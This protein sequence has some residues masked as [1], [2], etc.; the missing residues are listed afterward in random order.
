MKIL[1]IANSEGH[2][3]FINYLKQGKNTVNVTSEYPN[4]F[5]RNSKPDVLFDLLTIEAG[6]VEEFYH[7]HAFKMTF[8]NCGYMD[9]NEFASR[10]PMY[11]MPML[12]INGFPGLIKPPLVEIASMHSSHLAL[13]TEYLEKLGLQPIHLPNR[14]GM[15]TPRIVSTIINEAYYTLMEGTASREH[16]D[17]SMKLGTNYPYGPF[18]WAEKIGIYKVYVLLE[19]LMNH[20]GEHRYRPCPL[21]RDEALEQLNEGRFGRISDIN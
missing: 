15:V 3:N 8:V 12:C 4:S 21:L 19:S 9:I 10:I 6:D 18:E 16:I 14:V 20:T 13:G 1:V 17:K 11:Q 7:L 2:G 5:P